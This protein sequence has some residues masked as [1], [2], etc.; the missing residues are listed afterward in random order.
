MNENEWFRVNDPLSPLHGCDVRGSEAVDVDED[1]LGFL[2]IEALRRV[3]VFVGD[4][5]HQLIAPKGGNLG[6][7]IDMDQ[8]EPSPIQNEIV[9]IGTD[10]PFGKCIEEYQLDR[11]DGV[12]IRVARF[13]TATQIALDDVD[14]RLARSIVLSGHNDVTLDGLTLMVAFRDGMDVFTLVEI[15][16]AY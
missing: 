6:L 16:S 2:M 4:R 13:E 10:R 15:M 3:D 1:S 12:A 7:M 8:L 14:G 9:E 11:A 5:P